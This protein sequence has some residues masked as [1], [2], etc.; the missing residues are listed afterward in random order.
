MRIDRDE[1]I[2]GVRPALLKKL[3]GRESFDTVTAMAYLG[4]AEPHIS[5]TLVALAQDGWIAYAGCKDHI[6]FWRTVEKAHRLGATRLIKR[7]PIIEGRRIARK[8][9]EEA[10]LINSDPS[11]SCRITEVILF[12][13]VLTGDEDGDAGDIDLVVETGRRSLGEEE[14]R[15]ITDA[16]EAAMPRHLGFFRRLLHV[17]DQLRRRIKKISTKIAIH[18]YSDLEIL[19]APHRRIYAYDAAREREL[20]VDTA[21]KILEKPNGASEPDETD[22]APSARA[23]ICRSEWPVAPNVPAE[24]EFMDI[25]QLLRAQHMWV[26]GAPLNDIAKSTRMSEETTQAYL[27]SRQA[28][29]PP[30]P[31]PFSPNLNAMVGQ[32]LVPGSMHRIVTR[33]VMHPGQSPCAE[34]EILDTETHAKLVNIRRFSPSSQI[35]KG[36]CDLLP[37]VEPANDA[38]WSWCQKMRRSLQGLGLNLLT[39]NIA[40]ASPMLQSAESPIDFQPL[41][42]PMLDLLRSLLPSPR[43]RYEVFDH[44][45]EIRLGQNVSIVHRVGDLSRSDSTVRRVK[46]VQAPNLWDMVRSFN[47]RHADA[48]DIGGF[49]TL[50]VNGS[51]L[52][53]KE[54]ERSD[55]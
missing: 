1:L 16:E 18:G 34:T 51:A 3:F 29:G 55:G 21:I 27:A 2:C 10:R 12:G 8:I 22:M 4:I 36:R 48:L 32:A 38:A 39:V 24:I 45:V 54:G 31:A 41:K 25:A 26:K 15:R 20:P 33:L 50:F 11:S 30:R 44:D 53:E 9:V 43:S 47:E 13:S 7:F 35:F 19:A 14:M 17:E 52:L 23:A 28:M 5:R 49:Y 42:A 6:D 37:F 46:K 40:D